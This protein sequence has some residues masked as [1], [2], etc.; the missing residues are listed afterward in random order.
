MKS[1][2]SASLLGCDLAALG[3]EIKS[4]E[5]AGADWLH[6]DVMDGV[7]VDN[8]SF[9]TPVLACIKRSADIPLDT[10]LM[11]TDPIRYVDNYADLGS[12]IITF[13]CEAASDPQAVIDRIH[14]HGIKAGISLR[15]VTPVSMLE[16]YLGSV[17]LVLVMTVDPGF[18]G[19]SFMP[20]MLEK[21]RAVR[22]RLEEMGRSEVYIEVDGGIN[23]KTV[24]LCREAG[25]NVMVS[26][27]Y[28]FE[29]QDRAAAVESLKI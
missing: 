25:A 5:Q 19:Q 14:S 21:I 1:L 28:I 6:C 26:G 9:G 17:D 11:I 16:P 7:F 22:S 15:P 3:S 4:I 10:H 8:I 27:S 23:D 2:V 18:G 13:H 24:K 12:D 20:E 29:A